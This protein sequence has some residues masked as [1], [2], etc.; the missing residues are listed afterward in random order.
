MNDT[1]FIVLLTLSILGALGQIVKLIHTKSYRQGRRI[2]R[3]ETLAAE[4]S[5]E[6][7]VSYYEAY[8]I[9]SESHP[10]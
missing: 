3:I 8:G 2:G 4:Y 10:K 6:F 5:R 1:V 7:K 9:V